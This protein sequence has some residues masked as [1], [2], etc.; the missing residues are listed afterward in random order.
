M[1][2]LPTIAVKSVPDAALLAATYPAR[3]GGQSG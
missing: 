1:L 3:Q 2:W